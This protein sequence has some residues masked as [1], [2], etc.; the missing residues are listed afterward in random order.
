MVIPPT[1]S[2]VLSHLDQVLNDTSVPLDVPAIEKL[3]VEFTEDTDR[4]VPATLLT[5]ISQLLPLL[6][7]DPTPLTTLGT[8]AA[9]YLSFSDV[10][11]IDPP[12]NLIAGIKAP[13][14]P[15]NLLAL[16]L[17]GKAG[18]TP[19]DAAIIA[20][21]SE[22]VSSV[23]E[24]W[25]STSTTAVSQAA[26]DVLWSLLEVDH[27]SQLEDGD[28]HSKRDE[29]AA[30]QGLM[31][32]RVFGDK[33]VYGLFFSICGL[34]DALIPGQLT[35]Q[36]RT[37]A[38]GRLM[39]FIVKAASLRWD[40]VSESHIPDIE[41]KYESSSL[42]HFAA[43]RMV[44]TGDVLMH[45]TLLNF[46]RELLQ[47]GAPGL[48]ARNYL[49]S[50]STVSSPALDFLE[51]Q[52]L[53]STLLGYYL[54]DG[55]Q[56]EI[57]DLLYLSSPIMAYVARYAQMYPNHL[58]QNS[59]ET[60]DKILEKIN[61][62]FA[63]SSAQWAHGAVPTGDLIILSCLPRVML[64][65]AGR[66]S[67]NPLL[68]LPT[69]PPNRECYEALARIFQGPPKPQQLQSGDLSSPTATPTNWQKEAAAARVLYFTYL[70]S[71]ANMW[72]DITTAADIVAMPDV[73]LAALSLTKAVITANW[74]P[75]SKE[76]DTDSAV[77]HFRLP[78]ED[79]FG[80]LSPSSQGI[81][82]LTGCWAVLAPPALTSVLP[83]LFKPPPSY[84]NF[85][86]GGR[87]DTESAVW[88]IAT[89]KYDVLVSLH[90]ALKENRGQ[91]EGFDD[92]L[93]TLAQRVAQGPWGP[94]SQAGS[95][96][97]ALEM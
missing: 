97:D 4:E 81:L 44:D 73:A 79:E 64:V 46:Y 21:N 88:R 65:E 80:R 25:L 51:A 78:T 72:T 91:M 34:V 70:N 82:P 55:S 75:L 10:R 56:L 18:R 7:E 20:G 47:I 43:C 85:V 33:D 74:E 50:A 93:R 92:I 95:R 23:V 24:L 96:V 37:V 39:D 67:L 13:S 11:S 9:E 61:R 94:T 41:S 8:K 87:G 40:A 17:L 19:S 53:H 83:Y 45:M 58:L 5:R 84:A 30:G 48:E 32:R 14:P 89:A 31:W 63:I 52:G 42:L 28:Q 60:L 2:S 29:A 59:Q 76:A 69:N 26:F 1:Y 86:G 54:S 12:V 22:L 16:S 77:S 6:Q 38:Q 57:T 35:K 66:R 15:V 36:E 3:K 90:G 62:S 71:H 49:R 68:E 27:A